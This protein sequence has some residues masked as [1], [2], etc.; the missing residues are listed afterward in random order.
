MKREL[1]HV[2]SMWRIKN[3]LKKIVQGNRA[4]HQHV[5]KVEEQVD[6]LIDHATDANILGRTWQGWMPWM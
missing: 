5:L 1:E 2:T 3:E 4:E 6:H